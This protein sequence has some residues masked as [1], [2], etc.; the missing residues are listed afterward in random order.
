MD[1]GD[2]GGGMH[3]GSV[4]FRFWFGV[5]I[6]FAVWFGFSC[7]AELPVIVDYNKTG[8]CKPPDSFS[9]GAV[10][11]VTMPARVQPSEI[12]G[13]FHVFSD[14]C[15]HGLYGLRLVAVERQAVIRALPAWFKFLPVFPVDLVPCGF[16]GFAVRLSLFHP[17][18]Y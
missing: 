18:S 17:S 3:G 8:T 1:A 15:I 12:K 5:L 6:W 11:P 9:R 10:A 14:T 16:N 13:V 7:K 4:H 2:G